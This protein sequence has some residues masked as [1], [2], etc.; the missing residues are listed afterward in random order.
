MRDRP[1]CTICLLWLLLLAAIVCGS[2]EKASER[3]SP[4][5]IGN[6]VEDGE[7]VRCLGT[8]FKKETTEERQIY[9]LKNVSIFIH[10]HSLKESRI[11]I[12]DGNDAKFNSVD[13]HW[14]KTEIYCGSKVQISGKLRYFEPARNPGNFDQKAYYARKK[15]HASVW[16]EKM[17]M[18]QG[19]KRNWREKLWRFREAW[20]KMLKNQMGEEK[21]GI[22]SAMLLGDKKT[23]DQ[24]IKELYQVNGI[25][26]ILAI[27][28]LHLSILGTGVYQ[29]LRRASGSYLLGGLGG[30]L[31]LSVYVFLVGSSVSVERAFIMFL[32][33][34]GADMTGRKY[35]SPTALGVAAV[36]ILTRQPLYLYDGGFWM[37][38]GAVLAMLVVLPVFESF[39]CQNLWAGVSTQIFLL[40]VV[41]MSYYEIPTFSLL[42]NLLVIPLLTVLLLMAVAASI[43]W[44]VFW[45][46]TWILLKGCAG[47]LMLYEKSCRLIV[48][49][50]GARLV[51]GKPK[52][53][54]CVVYYVFLGMSLWIIKNWRM[55]NKEKKEKQISK[56]RNKKM[57]SK[58]IFA[59]LG[60]LMAFLALGIP[61]NKTSGLQVTMLDVGQGDGIFIR[62]PGGNAYLM[63]GGSSD[64]KNVGKYR[65][66]PYLK[67]QGIGAL[68]GV[69]VSHGDADHM[70]GI[71][72]MLKRQNIGV[73]IKRL[74]L[75]PVS[76]WD[77]N[78]KDL[79]KSAEANGT[80]VCIFQRGQRISEQ[81]N[82][83][84]FRIICLGPA[85]GSETESK[86]GCETEIK[87]GN[88]A[89]M[90]LGVEYEKLHILLTSDVEGTGEEA[91]TE[92]LRHIA[93]RIDADR[94]KSMRWNVLKV[95]HHGSKNS[96][97]DSFLEAVRPAYALISAGENNRYGHPHKETIERLRK[98]GSK[99]YLTAKCGAVTIREKKEKAWLTQTLKNCYY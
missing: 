59:G 63:D 5:R 31:M 72:E 82:S 36:I 26:H 14:K 94:G 6:Y 43:F 84:A 92:Y 21:G 75:P 79:A 33:R 66:E 9:Y 17:E 11:I 71:Q 15:I 13:K 3:F 2:G 83:N 30:L 1:L 42:L 24:E 78:L 89:S 7:K 93:Q 91:L 60:I 62:T 87:P 88:E 51:L 58:L 27:S 97:K 48:E 37:S 54:Q 52:L 12:Y 32:F 69:F 57:I 49:M 40:P 74:I 18:L 4:S 47:I 67:S 90:V 70:N 28:G 29:M 19:E 64:V 65:L 22:L 44:M 20:K 53:W 25:A 56:Q 34:V 16:A 61:Q 96:T 38:F 95:A 68:D 86:T 39:P 50:S 81:K 85:T 35:D 23:M 76:V 73:K 8:V 98:N 41:L 99:Y 46:G 10:G 77:E 45:P 55:K 80:K